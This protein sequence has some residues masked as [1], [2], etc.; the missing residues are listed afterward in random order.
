M[1]TLYKEYHEKLA[2]KI[3]NNKKAILF[4]TISSEPPNSNKVLGKNKAAHIETIEFA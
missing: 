1:T 2:I 3:R 4:N